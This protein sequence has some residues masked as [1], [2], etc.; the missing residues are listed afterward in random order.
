MT[1]FFSIKDTGILIET[2]D[3]VLYTYFFPT[4]VNIATE[5]SAY[6]SGNQRDIRARL[7]HFNSHPGKTDFDLFNH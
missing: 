2:F 7:S 3:R 1:E 5:I 6:L 4:Q